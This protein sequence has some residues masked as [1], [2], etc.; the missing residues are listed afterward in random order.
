M[1]RLSGLIENEDIEIKFSGLNEGEKLYEELLTDKE[2]L[3]NSHNK[4]IFIAEKQKI[5]INIK[6]MI[7]KLIKDASNSKDINHLVSSIM[8][9][10]PEFKST[11]SKYRKLK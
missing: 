10:V 9:I 7:L 5:D 1:I 6:T 2:N 3:K 8:N 11:N 4:L